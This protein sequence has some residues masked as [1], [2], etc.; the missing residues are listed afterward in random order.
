MSRIKIKD[1]NQKNQKNKRRNGYMSDLFLRRIFTAVIA[2]LLMTALF[3]VPDTAKA[4]HTVPNAISE[5]NR[6]VGYWDLRDRETFFQVTNTSPNPIR[7]HIQIFDVDQSP[8]SAGECFEFDYFDTLTP[9]D[10]HVY[11]ISS[12]DRNNGIPLS[13]P[14]LEGG[15]GIIAISHVELASNDFN[16]DEVLTGNTRIVDV[17]GYEYRVNMS[18]QSD[19]ST[20]EDEYHI[21]FNDAGATIFADL[22]VMAFDDDG[23]N[24]VPLAKIYEVELFDAF[25]NP[26][27]CPSIALGCGFIDEDASNPF[28]A[29]INVGINQAITNSRGGPSVCAGNDTVGFLNEFERVGS[30]PEFTLLLIGLNNGA[31][32]GG[33][34]TGIGD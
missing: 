10:T 30:N 13:A 33:M 3:V 11:N 34:H 22:V 15:H 2:V 17:T 27:S 26:I 20:S 19:D 28:I 31:G 16:S 14:N 32:L 6:L 18:W 25:E 1:I 5:N 23:I 24:I 7:I 21:Q 4:S 12:L 9:E 29:N 8:T